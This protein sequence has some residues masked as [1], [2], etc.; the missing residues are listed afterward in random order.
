MNVIRFFFK[1]WFEL[2]IYIVNVLYLCYVDFIE[3][4]KMFLGNV[5]LK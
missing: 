3:D 1:F 4:G 5:K 2:D